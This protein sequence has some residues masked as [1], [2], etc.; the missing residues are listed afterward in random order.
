MSFLVTYWLLFTHDHFQELDEVLI[1]SISRDFISVA[2]LHL[3]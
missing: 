1:W 3:A 2:S